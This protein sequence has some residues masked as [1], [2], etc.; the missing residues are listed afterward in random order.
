MLFTDSGKYRCNLEIVAARLW[1]ENR[2]ATTIPVE[3]VIFLFHFRILIIESHVNGLAVWV[4]VSV[5]DLSI[6]PY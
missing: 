2:T 1:R 4:D 3:M 5:G 6:M